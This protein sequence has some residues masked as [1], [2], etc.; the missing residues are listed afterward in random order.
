M[1]MVKLL[2]GS[3]SLLKN[4]ICNI[5]C[6][7]CCSRL[8]VIYCQGLYLSCQTCQVNVVFCTIFCCNAKLCDRF[9]LYNDKTCF[10]MCF[11]LLL[12]LS[13][14]LCIWWEIIWRRWSVCLLLFCSH[15]SYRERGTNNRIKRQDISVSRDYDDI[16]HLF[17]FLFLGL[18]WISMDRACDGPNV[19]YWSYLW[20][21]SN[22]FFLIFLIK[23]GGRNI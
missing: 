18:G 13:T 8:F 17:S 15:I 20:T 16:F 7:P 5:I 22:N 12:L 10:W 6:T 19:S 4:K 11:C 9:Y 14:F 21:K 2:Y 3:G 1:S 23:V